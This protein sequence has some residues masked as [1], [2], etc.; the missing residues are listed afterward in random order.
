MVLEGPKNINNYVFGN[1]IS[2]ARGDGLFLLNAENFTLSQNNIHHNN[3]GILAATGVFSIVDNHIHHNEKNGLLLVD[4]N[5]VCIRDNCFQSN[6]EAG[7]V[8]RNCTRGTIQNNTFSQ[9]KAEIVME[10][11]HPSLEMIEEENMFTS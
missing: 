11:D 5:Y 1:T 3:N 8:I 9:N 4:D 2:N 6:T 7:L 10:N